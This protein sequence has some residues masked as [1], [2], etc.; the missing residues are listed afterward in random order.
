MNEYA[1]EL[2]KCPHCGSFGT[3]NPENSLKAGTVL[4]GRYTVGA[5]LSGDRIKNTISYISYDSVL[6][7][8]TVVCEYFPSGIM[9]R[10]KDSG[11]CRLRRFS[12]DASAPCAKEAFLTAEGKICLKGEDIFLLFRLGGCSKI[13]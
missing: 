8:K 1:K 13:F 11:L 6:G 3:Q 10:E 5:V 9:T 7:N 12:K 2:E 4:N